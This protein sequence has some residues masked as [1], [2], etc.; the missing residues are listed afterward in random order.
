GVLP[1]RGVDVGDR[2]AVIAQRSAPTV[3]LVVAL[4]ALGRVPLVVD[5]RR[6]DIAH[7]LSVGRPEFVLDERGMIGIAPTDFDG[8]VE[9]AGPAEP[10]APERTAPA[11]VRFASGTTATATGVVSTQHGLAQGAADWLDAQGGAPLDT[12]GALQFA[13]TGFDVFYEDIVRALAGRYR[14]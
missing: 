3:R 5:P 14:L 10:A 6:D 11:Y 7:R 13:G 4:L 8:E 9:A 1:A 12:G 2:V